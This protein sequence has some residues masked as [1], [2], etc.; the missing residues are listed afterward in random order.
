MF[1]GFI[2]VYRAEVPVVPV[3]PEV[4]GLKNSDSL[5][6]SEVKLSETF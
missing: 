5:I 6:S 1:I 4:P 2:E 3:V